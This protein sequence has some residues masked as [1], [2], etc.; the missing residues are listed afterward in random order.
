MKKGKNFFYRI[1]PC[2]VLSEV[3]FAEDKEK[4]FMQFFN[5]LRNDNPEAA[6]IPLA[7]DIIM[8]AQGFRAKRSLAGKASAEQRATHVEHMLKD[9]EHNTTSVQPVA[10]AVAVAVAEPTTDTKDIKTLPS[11]ADEVDLETPFMT[12]K[13]K[14]KLKGHNLEMFDLFWDAFSYKH[15]KIEAADSWLD[16][17]DMDNALFDK[18]IS[19]AKATAEARTKLLSEGKTPKMAQ[20]WLSG[21]RW[22]DEIQQAIATTGK[23]GLT[24]DFKKRFLGSD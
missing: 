16:I 5:D 15:G 13:K 18:I 14:R 17:R 6:V 7:A 12:T 3:I 19:A 4:W 9:V 2:E 20:G 1:N 24:D 23:G 8:E 11:S 21:R 22:D 10:V